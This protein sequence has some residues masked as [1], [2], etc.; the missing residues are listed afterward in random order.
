M[1]EEFRA[2]NFES[3]LFGAEPEREHYAINQDAIQ[4]QQAQLNNRRKTMDSHL[5]EDQPPPAPMPASTE[6]NRRKNMESQLAFGSDTPSPP[7]QSVR[8]NQPVPASPTR[9]TN[10]IHL[11][12]QIHAIGNRIERQRYETR[13]PTFE[14]SETR[15][16]LKAPHRPAFLDTQVKKPDMPKFGSL[17]HGSTVPPLAPFPELHLEVTPIESSFEFNIKPLTSQSSRPKRLQI[18]QANDMRKMRDELVKDTA[19]FEGRMK[20]IPAV[21][22][23]TPI[24][25]VTAV[26]DD[27]P[28]LDYSFAPRMET[29]TDFVFLNTN[30]YQ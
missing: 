15:P 11:D 26:A 16:E 19:A 2:R 4:N 3:H 21:E 14:V 5:F 12:N 25:P 24:R 17:I 1:G 7:Q 9:Y 20:Q 8:Q 22:I 6:H 10:D 27:P 18:T 30:D 23:M 29:A 28:R 13:T